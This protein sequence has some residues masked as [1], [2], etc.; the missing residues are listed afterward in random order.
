LG[1]IMNS[2]PF[3]T[4]VGTMDDVHSSNNTISHS[5]LVADAIAMAPTPDQWLMVTPGTT[6]PKTKAGDIVP[7]LHALLGFRRS[8]SWIT[9]SAGSG[10]APE[11]SCA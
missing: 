9:S 10:Q 11:P 8:I 7:P 5:S 2:T 4:I 3:S 6:L 1:N